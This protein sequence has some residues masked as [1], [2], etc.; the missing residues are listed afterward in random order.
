MALN[1]WNEVP[2]KMYF[3]SNKGFLFQCFAICFSLILVEEVLQS[4][5]FT[6]TH[7]HVVYTIIWNILKL[8]SMLTSFWY[9]LFTWS[10]HRFLYKTPRL[11][12]IHRWMI[13][14]WEETCT[15]TIM[16]PSLYLSL[17]LSLS[18]ILSLLYLV[19]IQMTNSTNIL[20]DLKTVFHVWLGH[21]RF[22]F[23]ATLKPEIM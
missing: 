4:N 6:H 22:R 9:S 5:K 8:V 14:T 3:M 21:G 23:S 12:L 1:E 20:G 10:C 13:H 7:R 2:V 17:S 18:R 11:Q 16:L 15:Q 19:H